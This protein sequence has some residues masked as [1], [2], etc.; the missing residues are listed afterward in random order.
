VGDL[1]ID[2]CTVIRRW[3]FGDSAINKGHIAYFSLRM[4]DTAIFYFR[5]KIWRHHRV[6]RPRF[7]FLKDAKISAI[8]IHLRQ[9]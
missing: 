2:G 4:R 1:S 7:L 6:P 3:N 5:S 8:R 9:K